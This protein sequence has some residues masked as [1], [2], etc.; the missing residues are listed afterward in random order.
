[1]TIQKADAQP[2]KKAELRIAGKGITPRN[3]EE[4][5]RFSAMVF[6]SGLCPSS[7]K[8]AQQVVVA[9]QM[10]LEVGLS[11]LQA[12]NG[13]AVIN[14]RPSI[15]GDAGTALVMNSGLLED[16][17][18][19]YEGEGDELTAVCRLKRKGLKGWIEGSFSIGDA[20][21]AGL[22]SKKGPWQEYPRRMLMW[23]ARSFAYR[24]GFADALKGLAFVE[25][26]RDI[27][28]EPREISAEV[29]EERAARF[30]PVEAQ[31][32]PQENEEHETEPDQESEGNS[33]GT[34]RPSAA[35]EFEF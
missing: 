2:A 33:L 31:P 11:P 29:V 34:E 32:A 5:W 7:I 26:V 35:E 14:G 1:M 17:E 4:L 24:D 30:A 22:L 12:L 27:S 8:T 9:V 15:Y 25:E 18:E 23:R 6:E 20:K 16:R 19:F 28:E 21:R 13:I 3:V 10:G